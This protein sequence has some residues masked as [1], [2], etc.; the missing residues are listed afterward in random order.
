MT[1]G[2]PFEPFVINSAFVSNMTFRPP[3][4]PTFDTTHIINTE[5]FPEVVIG[6]DHIR[7]PGTSGR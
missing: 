3:Q 7:P 2:L 5:I 1:F 6:L 4:K